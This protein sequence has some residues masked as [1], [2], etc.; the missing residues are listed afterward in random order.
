MA[1]VIEIIEAPKEIVEVIQGQG[2]VGPQ[3]PVGATGATGAVGPQ[4]PSGTTDYTQ[5]INKP[6]I[7]QAT[8]QT[9]VTL[10]GFL[11]LVGTSSEYARADH[12]HSI[13]IASMNATDLRSH[14]NVAD[15]A[16]RN[17]NADWTASSGD[18]QILNKPS[19]FTPAVHQHAIS[20]VTNLQTELD[21]KLQAAYD[22]EQYIVTAGLVDPEQLPARRNTVWDVSFIVSGNTRT[23]RLPAGASVR[24]GDRLILS[25]TAPLNTTV[26]ITRPTPAGNSS[27]ATIA[28]GQTFYYAAEV[29]GVSIGV[30]DWRET[31][32]LRGCAPSS[33]THTASAISDSTTAGRALL[34]AATV[35]AQRTAL[36]TFVSA[37]NLTAIQALTGNFQR[38]YI[39]QDT[40]KIYAWSGSGS[41]YTEISPNTHT[42]A[43]YNNTSVNDTALASGFLT[44][45]SNTAVGSDALNENTDG[46]QNTAVGA[47]ALRY[48]TT[49]DYNTAVG[50]ASMST[51]AVT[52]DFNTGVG[53]QACRDIS[54]GTQNSAFGAGS[55]RD[56]QAGSNNTAVGFTSLVQ[57]SGSGNTA[58]G[59]QSGD[60]ITSGSNNTIVGATADVDIGARSRC[61][62]LGVGATSPALDGTLAIGGT[63]TPMENL[64]TATAPT[65]AT[66]YLRVWLN[67][68][69]HRILVQKPS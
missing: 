62:L 54:S 19:T 59:V 5:L 16:E 9:P 67:G 69:E 34:T 35:Q 30:P 6:A 60:S 1:D 42:R 11:A 28:G 50:F 64:T 4:G 48:S 31:S 23:I 15:G 45:P 8:S 51:N 25:G 29:A 53:I 18:A 44:G 43:G 57:T 68:Q 10:G 33:H 46:G 7:P 26:V 38:V 61:L 12:K 14:L 36:E 22:Y 24:N 65:G 58:V 66:A 32:T 21:A 13:E 63:G 47:T 56:N 27:V 37:A 17:V 2:P 49:A 55:L 20:D 40:G 41:V 52:G 3:G 39:A